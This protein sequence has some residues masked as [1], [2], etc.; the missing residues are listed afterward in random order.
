MNCFQ[1]G[2][3][4][5]G[6]SW[7][8]WQISVPPN[9]A[10]SLSLLWICCWVPSTLKKKKKKKK[11][12]QICELIFIWG[13]LKTIAQ[14]TAFQI[15]LR[16]CSKDVEGRSVYTWSWWRGVNAIKYIYILQEVSVSSSVGKESACNA[17]DLG[18]IP[19]LERSPGE[20][21]GNPLQC[22][23]LKNPMDRGAW[24]VRVHGV[25]R[26]RHDLALSFCFFFLLV[27]R[28][29]HHHEGFYCFSRYEEIQE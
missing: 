27:T 7:G 11:Q 3:H 28:N 25:A 4:K 29:S 6:K 13:Q 26:V 22:S 5:V 14:E 16:N 9:F 24:Q 8:I 12:W 1:I 10:V 21:N 17:G 18:S 15:T 20:G 2:I 19:G 23:C